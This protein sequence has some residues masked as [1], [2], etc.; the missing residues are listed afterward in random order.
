[1][2]TKEEFEIY[3]E[4]RSKGLTN[5]FDVRNVISLSSGELTR[6]DC[7]EIMKNYD[8]LMKK[9]PDVRKETKMKKGLKMNTKQ[10]KTI[11]WYR[12]WQSFLK[13]ADKAEFR[14]L[15]LFS[16]LTDEELTPKLMEI[17]ETK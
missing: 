2:I 14:Y 13:K 17:T 9:Y 7:L 12:K 8:K 1:M 15:K 11:Q 16:R 3:E 10:N 6:D 4:I 5:M